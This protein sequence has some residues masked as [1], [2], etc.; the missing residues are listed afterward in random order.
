MDEK[1]RVR[2]G[3]ETSGFKRDLERL[4]GIV[5][6][7]V[8]KMTLAFGGL[9]VSSALIGSKFENELMKAATVANAY[10]KDLAALEQKARSIGKTTEF[11]ATQ[12]ATAMY[13]L[14]SAG[15][16][17]KET[18]AAVEDS[19]SLAG[20]T[21]SNLATVTHLMAATMK[22]F[23]LDAS[24]T[25][26]IADTY[27]AAITESL[28]TTESLAE[29]MK[30]AG[31]AGAAFRWSIEQTAAA[32]ALFSD[33]GLEGSMAGTNLRMSMLTLSSQTKNVTD[34]LKEL[35]LKFEDIN[36][37][38]HTFGEILD[39]IGRKSVS[40]RQAVE[41][42]GARAGLNMKQLAEMSVQGVISFDKLTNSFKNAQEGEGRAT[43]M[44]KRMMD[45]FSGQWKHFWNAIKELG[46]V[47]FDTYKLEGKKMFTY[48]AEQVNYFADQVKNHSKDI[49]LAMYDMA[50]F[51][52][53]AVRSIGTAATWAVKGMIGIKAVVILIRDAFRELNLKVMEEKLPSLQAK[54][55]ALNKEYEARKGKKIWVENPLT[56]REE[57]KPLGPTGTYFERLNTPKGLENLELVKQQ[58]AALMNLNTAKMRVEEQKELIKLTRVTAEEFAKE[59]EWADKVGNKFDK[60]LDDLKT[61]FEIRRGRVTSGAAAY[62][63]YIGDY[64][65]S[66]TLPMQFDLGKI[67]GKMEEQ[68]LGNLLPKWAQFEE[69][70]VNRQFG[71]FAYDT[72]PKYIPESDL[73]RKED[74][75]EYKDWMKDLKKRRKEI[76]DDINDYFLKQEKDSL[77]AYY[78]YEEK[79]R[80]IRKDFALEYSKIGKDQYQIEIDSI[81][82]QS[83]A[84]INAEADKIQVT[85][86]AEAEIT[87]I[88]GEQTRARLELV[89]GEFGKV[90]ETAKNILDITQGKSKEAFAI[91]KAFAMAQVTVSGVRAV[92]AALASGT[93]SGDIYA[94]YAQAAV[95]ATFAAAQIAAIQ[96]A[97]TPSYDQGGVS[98][99]PGIYYSG[100][101]EAHIPLKGG[102]V[103]VRLSG[104]QGNTVIVR[105]ENPVFQDAA[106]QRRTMR[107]LAEEVTMRL[108]PAALTANYNNDGSMRRIIRSRS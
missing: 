56:G 20:A 4:P 96:S 2:V 105:M 67:G 35:N 7:A 57:L 97:K 64:L 42:F 60:I 91:Y 85:K 59:F 78:D 9:I 71:K 8:K 26:R 39:I 62:E 65:E 16:K 53:E 103:P 28:L 48:L 36:P 47:F 95:A 89:A 23:G 92:M 45:T 72:T 10:G 15:L 76:D 5:T 40:S 82:T 88:K 81:K 58:A 77:D 14:V 44:Y 108:A 29:A 74:T 3:A 37:E 75:E 79:K 11:S 18:M 51:S 17:V 19:V 61:G 69:E 84:Y 106:T 49:K 98:T 80:D 30:Y 41:L 13:D 54:F 87:R 73:A 38:T 34:T 66:L 6:S 52:V 27:A 102:N 104:N 43:E 1:L 68:R 32:V 31:T 22:Q 101:P 25:K 99:R 83:E 70:R 90:A 100:V 12:A 86:W 93:E 107:I 63:D 94:G 24:Q 55:D 46:L 50:I 21:G 33:L